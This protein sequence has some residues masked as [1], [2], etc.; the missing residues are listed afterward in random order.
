MMMN[1]KIMK[2]AVMPFMILAASSLMQSCI[3]EEFPT[4]YATGEQMQ[5]AKNPGKILLN[6]LNA[7]MVE[8]FS[9]NGAQVAYDWGYP[10]QMLIRDILG[11]DE[12]VSN[13]TN[14][15]LA[16]IADGTSLNMFSLYTYSYYYDLVSNANNMVEKF[17]SADSDQK[18]YAGAARVYRALAY[19][20][21]T[22]MFEY[23][24]TGFSSLDA[25]AENSKVAGLTVPI[26]T[27][28]TTAK[29]SKNNPR[30]PFYTMYRFILNDLKLAESE[31]KGF[32]RANK[33]QPDESVVYGLEARLWLEMATR[34]EKIQ[35]TW[36]PSSLMRKMLMAT[37]SW[38]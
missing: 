32:E 30:A 26:V 29:E 33:T 7:K 9:Y 15:Y 24:T 23:K 12:P 13:V 2:M 31:M 28:K 17:G 21:M 8:Q 37:L 27:E 22:R 10:S 18:A 4:D 25:Q 35:K 38:V 34:F 16:W 11:G 36:L 1:K 5:T 6:G 20:D 14:D 3:E 19:L